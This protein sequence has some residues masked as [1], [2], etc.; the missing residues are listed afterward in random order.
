MPRENAAG[1]GNMARTGMFRVRVAVASP[2]AP[3][4]SAARRVSE[5]SARI[6]H[7]CS[8]GPS[9]L[10]AGSVSSAAAEAPRV[11]LGTPTRLV[12]NCPWPSSKRQ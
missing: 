12:S 2:Q 1:S 5:R 3:E 8:D 4:R 7:Y 11:P 9:L 10:Q 6:G